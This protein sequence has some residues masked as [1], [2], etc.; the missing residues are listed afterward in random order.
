L[1]TLHRANGNSKSS[2]ENFPE[3]IEEVAKRKKE[4][5]REKSFRVRGRTK[6]KFGLI[7]DKTLGTRKE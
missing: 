3:C 6:A 7:F 1:R 4:R 5:E 2:N